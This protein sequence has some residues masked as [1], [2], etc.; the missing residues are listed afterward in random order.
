MVYNRKH[1]T[2]EQQSASLHSLQISSKRGGCGRKLNPKISQPVLRTAQTPSF[3]PYREC[4]HPRYP[5]IFPTNDPNGFLPQADLTRNM[6]QQQSHERI[7]RY[8]RTND[9][10]LGHSWASRADSSR[11]QH[12]FTFTDTVFKSFNL[13]AIL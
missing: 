13:T 9:R 1:A 4:F 11:R 10:I 5:S 7:G 3:A 6:G 2:E 12:F 8:L